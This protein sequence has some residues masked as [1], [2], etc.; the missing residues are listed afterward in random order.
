MTL[1]QLQ[2]RG[3][4]DRD[5]IE[6]SQNFLLQS[7]EQKYRQQM[8]EQL[9]QNQRLSSEL[10]E[11]VKY[12]EKEN[13][14]LQNR[15]QLELRDQ[16]SEHGSMEKK[17]QDLQEAEARYHKE[18]DELKGERD[19]RIVDNQRALDKERET[20]KTKI[21]D[22]E[23]KCKELESKRSTM[24]FEFEKEKAKWGLE[25]DFLTSQKQEVQEQV[26]RVQRKQEQLLKENERLKSE[27]TR[28]KSYL[29]GQG[30]AGGAQGANG[31]PPTTGGQYAS[32]FN[33][34]AFGQ[35]LLKGTGAQKENIGVGSSQTFAQGFAKFISDGAQKEGGQS[36]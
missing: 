3:S 35:H 33:S 21:Q 29:Y 4:A 1:E 31:V 25:K 32:K 6:N 36:D 2:K 16:M 8:R 22:I 9:D 23:Q 17:V 11:K 5:K 34:T 12:L 30:N 20:F 10:S 7:I 18:I 19:R 26:E 14:Q 24:F 28:Q 15:L 27:K 13:I